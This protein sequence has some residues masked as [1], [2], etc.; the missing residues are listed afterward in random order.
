MIRPC[1]DL[2]FAAM[3]AI[4]NDGAEAYRGVIPAD[5]WHQPYM[6]A[7][8]LYHEL[9]SGVRFWGYRDGG[10]LLGVMGIQDVQDVTLIRHAYVR[11]ANR[12]R[13][14]GG[15]LLAELRTLTARPVLV[16]TWAAAAWAIGFYEK[17]GF[18]LVTP[19]EKNRLLKRYW[20][21]P[22]RQ[23]ETSVVL[24]DERWFSYR[25][26]LVHH[27]DETRS[28]ECPFGDVQRIVTGGAGGV[29]NVH[30][31]KITKGTPHVHEG[32]DEVYYVLAGCGAITLGHETRP[33]RP[34]SVAVIPAGLRH[35]LDASPGEQLEFVIFGTP[36]MAMDDKRATP[37]KTAESI[38]ADSESRSH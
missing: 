11:T 10:E 29:A 30:V 2:D 16:G 4:I 38:Q 9:A 24:G 3:L 7:D 23:V 20:S 35:S 18:R 37:I 22:D 5:R 27:R 19:E 34:G 31:V 25:Q 12:S 8:E 26:P 1:D 6:S 32:Y 14:I 13:G 36:P 15:K 33:L 28:I 21:I 17:H